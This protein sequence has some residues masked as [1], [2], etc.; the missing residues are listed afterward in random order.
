MQLRVAAILLCIS[1]SAQTILDEAYTA[2]REAQLEEAAKRF[3]AGL[4]ENPGHLNA[5]KD[6]AYTL[7]RLGEPARAREEFGEVWHRDPA[8]WTSA[9]EYAFLC[10]ETQQRAEA[11][12]VFDR[13]RL[14]ASGEAQKTA[15]T[16]FR[17]IDSQ[18]ETRIRQWTE[19]VEK[20]PDSDTVHEELAE[21]ASDRD[22]LELAEK[23]FAEALRLKPSKRRFL[24]KLGDIRERMGKRSEALASYVAASRSRDVRTSERGRER[25]PEDNLSDEV[26][27]LADLYEPAEA[28]PAANYSEVSTLEMADRSYKLGFMQD[29]LRYYESVQQTEPGNPHVLTRLGWTENML[30][31][32]YEAYRWFDQARRSSKSPEDREVVK[33]AQRAWRNLRASEAGV[34]GTLWVLPMYS[35]RWQSAFAYGQARMEFR[36]G[37]LPVRPYLSMRF[38][39][40]AWARNA[41]GPLSERAITPA[42]GIVTK[43]WRRVTFWGEAGGN[44]GNIQGK[45]FRA[46]AAHARGFGQLLGGETSGAFYLTENA[47]NYA[48]RFDNNVMFSSQNRFGYTLGRIQAGWLFAAGTDT[49][50]EYWANYWEFGPTLRARIPGMPKNMYLNVDLVQGWNFYNQYNPRPAAYR[51]LRIGVWFAIAY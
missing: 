11:R 16:A 18:L 48:S 51:D 7:L 5:R 17:N 37:K 22:E 34:R 40:D 41:P 42:A 12:R 35:T 9:L 8:D 43:P 47:V 15:E 36:L 33:E 13:V 31:N 24:L 10:H 20:R 38:A 28:E 2:L 27:E 45:D 23:H 1:G 6:Y 46:G 21:L 49:R 4:E 25:L 39:H 3:Q 32:N 14:Q 29:A 30:G 44:V 50:R 26:L 19:A